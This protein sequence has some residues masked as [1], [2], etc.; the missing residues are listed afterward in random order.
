M[1]LSMLGTEEMF[2]TV[3]VEDARA[4]KSERIAEFLKEKGG[5]AKACQSIS[6]AFSK[7]AYLQETT[8]EKIVA[9]GSLYFIGEVLR[10]I[11]KEEMQDEFSIR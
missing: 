4:E 7:A 8:G 1:L 10:W 2:F 3:T 9:F 11:K 6:E 5:R